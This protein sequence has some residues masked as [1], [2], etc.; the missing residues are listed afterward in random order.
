MFRKSQQPIMNQVTGEMNLIFRARMLWRDLA[1]WVRNYL[2]SIIAGVGDQEAVG[3]RLYR[4]PIEY[5]NV[6][7]VFF[8]D[9]A[10]EQYITMLSQYIVDLQLLYDAQISNDI[11]AINQQTQRLYANAD[12]RAAFFASINP[13]WSESVWQSLFYSFTS[14]LIEESTSL[15]LRDYVRD[16]NVFDRAISLTSVMGDYFSEGLINYLNYTRTS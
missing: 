6:L 5:G 2:I 4:L 1:T 16:I 7:R 9:Q 13:F 14:M 8:G 10:T 11:D 12:A 15:L 3:Q